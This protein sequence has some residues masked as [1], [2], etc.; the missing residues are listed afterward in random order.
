MSD[1]PFLAF[2]ISESEIKSILDIFEK[3]KP[4]YAVEFDSDF[5]YDIKSFA[6]FENNKASDAGPFIRIT[7]AGKYFHLAFLDVTY[8]MSVG[9]YHHA[10]STEFQTWG[11]FNLKNDYGHI[12]IKNETFLDKIHELIHPIEL[13]FDDDN[14][15]SKKF[16]VLASDEM[17]ALSCLTPGFRN[18]I[19]NTGIADLIIEICGHQLIVGNEK[20]MDPETA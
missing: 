7:N 10:D 1:L 11:I 17:K 5:A 3:L 12:L 14:E 20:I 15:F 9:K 18:H 2:D 13:D 16:Y 6:S 19:K 8:N 4:R